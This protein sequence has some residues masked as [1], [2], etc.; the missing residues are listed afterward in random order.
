[1]TESPERKSVTIM[2]LR[3]RP[4]PRLLHRCDRAIMYVTQ[5]E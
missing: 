2:S 1:M 4:S 5:F 3:D